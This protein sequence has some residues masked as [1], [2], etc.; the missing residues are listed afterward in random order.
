MLDAATAAATGQET[1]E[2]TMEGTRARKKS[3]LD[4]REMNHGLRQY[5]NC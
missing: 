3:L 5:K 2:K 1:A 4:G